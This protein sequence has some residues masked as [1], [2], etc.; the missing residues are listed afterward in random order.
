MGI[1]VADLEVVDPV[2]HS[3]AVVID[4]VGADLRGAGVDAGVEIVAV[5]V[6]AAVA[7][8][9]VVVVRAQ[10]TE[11]PV[12]VGHAVAVVV[13]AIALLRH[14]RAFARVVV[15]AVIDQ[16]VSVLVQVIVVAET[17]A[18][19]VHTIIRPFDLSR[20]DGDVSIIA[21]R[22]IGHVAAGGQQTR[23]SR[24]GHVPVA[25]VVHVRVP[26]ERV[27]RGV[28]V[29]LVIAVVVDAVTQ[30]GG[31]H[32]D[33]GVGVIAVGIDRDVPSRLGTGHLAGV[34]IPIAVPVDVRV[35]DR[36]VDCATVDVAVAV[37]VHTV[38]LLIRARVHPGDGVVTVRGV[39]DVPS[40]HIAVLNG[41]GH[42]SVAVP[43]GVRV[44]GGRDLVDLTVAVVVDAVA[45]LVGTGIHSRVRVVTVIAAGVPTHRDVTG[46]EGIAP[47]AM[48]IQVGIGIPGERVDGA[49]LVGH[50]IAVVV[51]A[52]AL[53]VRAREDPRVGVVTVRGVGD[54]AAG[55][56]TGIG[57]FIHVPIVVS[58]GIRVPD[59]LVDRSTV[60]VAVAVVVDAVALLVHTGF[61]PSVGVVTVLAGREPIT[62]IVG[63]AT[64]PVTVV[65]RGVG[66]VELFGTRVDTV[67]VVIAVIGFTGVANRCITGNDHDGHIPIAV[68]VG[69]RVPGERVD[70]AVLVGHAIAVV[71]HAI[72][73]LVRTG[74]DPDLGVIA[75]RGVGNVPSGQVTG[76]GGVTHVPI[77]VPVGVRVPDL[78]VDRIVV[79]V[80]VTVVVDTIALLVRT[81]VDPSVGVVTVGGVADVPRG[82]HTVLNGVG[83][84]A[85]TIHVGVRVPDLHVDRIVVDVAVT[86][87]VDTIALLVRT[88]V[89]PS[90]G[91]VTVGGVRDVSGGGAAGG[92]G[93]TLVAV[94]VPVGVRVP[95]ERVDGAVLVGHA[96][97]VVVDAVAELDRARADVIVAVV[98]V[99]VADH[100]H[101]SV[102]V[103]LVTETVA[104][105]V[106]AV[107]LLVRTGVD[108][109]VGVV[110]V[111]AGCEAVTV[112]VAVADQTITVVVRGVGAVGLLNTGVDPG[113]GVVT[114]GG[115][116]DVPGG[117]AAGGLGVT[118]V[119]VTVRVGIRVPGAGVS[120]RLFVDITVAVVVDTVAELVRTGVDAG[121]R[122]V[123]VLGVL[124]VVWRH[125][126]AEDAAPVGVAIAIT[127][128]VHVPDE[129]LGAAASISLVV[130][131]IRRV[132]RRDHADDPDDPAE[133]DVEGL[134]VE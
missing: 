14:T 78:H 44:P 46:D 101:I 133:V 77:A 71:V 99:A 76:V 56:I 109:S 123:T 64:G 45:Q 73:P 117:L 40:R 50:A 60:D 7:V 18:V 112:R 35:P 19:L 65:V 31:R 38:A 122:V 67:V 6:G 72:A 47:I 83:H 37:V 107:A 84:V 57:G 1:L 104:V 9:V 89:D 3:G 66:A 120:S 70:G 21:I 134:H 86:V 13:D 39:G 28:L 55:L 74:V 29:G 79:D 63:A 110:A 75:V 48:P 42:V 96:I 90:V 127:V 93:V 68:P 41:V 53:L 106:D 116:R 58:I 98:T 118:R 26:G 124:G 121:V 114:V 33:R 131:Q 23:H 15:V 43:V 128:A 11:F 62:V 97:T 100:I 17:I 59:R 119:A 27:D 87:V 54:V 5:L 92:L 132:T 85:V 34:V 80:A 52:V 91:V 108:P 49:V 61:D 125:I 111:H 32:V 126:T 16:N 95:G 2:G 130:R 81:G 22:G 69:V 94:A 12:L 36:L 25:I 82:E 20:I 113:V 8:R 129:H 103:D 105:V 102:L 24:V 30:L 88:G 4:P 115:V 10:R 51:H